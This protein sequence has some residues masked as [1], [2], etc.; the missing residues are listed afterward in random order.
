VSDETH[1]SKGDALKLYCVVFGILC[2][3]VLV[4]AIHQNGQL[5]GY[6]VANAQA[7]RLLSGKG[8]PER[9]ST[10]MPSRVRDL[11]IEIEKMVNWYKQTVGG[12]GD[13]GTTIPETFMRNA[14]ISAGVKQAHADR[15]QSDLN[16][17]KRFVT[18]SR[19]F[20]YDPTTLAHFHE[21]LQ[22]V[23]RTSRYRVYEL[24]WKLLEAKDNSEPPFN[25]I[26]KPRIKVGFRTPMASDQ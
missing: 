9:T 5:E 2:V 6:Q 4:V 22:R 13:S 18:H 20:H 16:R 26:Q 19:T 25:K 17:A 8:L 3:V 21:L 14:A 15:D 7:D 11:A 24:S 12:E 1:E 23:E 10:G